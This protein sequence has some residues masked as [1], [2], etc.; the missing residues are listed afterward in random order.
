MKIA[1]CR[2]SLSLSNWIDL[3]MLSFS[4]DSLAGGVQCTPPRTANIEAPTQTN[5]ISPVPI[6]CVLNNPKMNVT[7]EFLK[8]VCMDEEWG[9]GK[10]V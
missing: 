2:V 4:R 5:V 1:S 9:L 10:R 3:W 7:E 6:N 8:N